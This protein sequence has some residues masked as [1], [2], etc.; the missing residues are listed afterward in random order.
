MYAVSKHLAFGCAIIAT[1]SIYCWMA[2]S[3]AFLPYAAFI[4]EISLVENARFMRVGA[5]FLPY[6][7]V[8][9]P[10]NTDVNLIDQ[11]RQKGISDE[12]NFIHSYENF[13]VITRCFKIDYCSFVRV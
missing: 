6:S 8:L 3:R 4:D 2:E 5:H 10:T 9:C 1:M 12:I 13:N 7:M 11:S